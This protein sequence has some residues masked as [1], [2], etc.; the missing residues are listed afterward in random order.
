MVEP[1]S[2]ENLPV[3]LPEVASY[4]PIGQQSNGAYFSGFYCDCTGSITFFS[5]VCSLLPCNHRHWR[6]PA[7]G[8]DRLGCDRRL[9]RRSRNPRDADDAAVGRQLLVLPAVELASCDAFLAKF[10]AAF[11]QFRIPGALVMR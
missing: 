1:V 7:R 4:K 3:C 11:I 6:E 9:G 5:C 8:R 10:H 2:L